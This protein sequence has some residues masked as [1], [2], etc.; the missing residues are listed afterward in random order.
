MASAKSNGSLLAEKSVQQALAWE[1][2]HPAASS[3]ARSCVGM[4]RANTGQVF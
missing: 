3:A 4:C 1:T 2:L